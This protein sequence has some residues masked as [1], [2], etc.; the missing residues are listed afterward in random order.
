MHNKMSFSSN[1]GP[2]KLKM[3]NSAASGSIISPASHLWRVYIS[4][5]FFLLNL[6]ILL[7]E[8]SLQKPSVLCLWKSNENFAKLKSSCTKLTKTSK[9]KT[10][11]NKWSQP[12]EWTDGR[13]NLQTV[14][15]LRCFL[16]FCSMSLVLLSS[17]LILNL[18]HTFSRYL[19]SVNL[20]WID[21]NFFFCNVNLIN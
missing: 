11:G 5:F 17:L 13:T 14:H 6:N 4:D 8:K 3:K 19:Y 12:Y 15:L 1:E 16:I 18:F 7:W 2:W 21:K 20:D 9:I 10:L